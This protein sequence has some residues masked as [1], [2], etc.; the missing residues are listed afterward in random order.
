MIPEWYTLGLRLKT[1]SHDDINKKKEDVDTAIK[2]AQP[3][4][5]YKRGYIVIVFQAQ[6][7]FGQLDSSF[8]ALPGADNAHRWKRKIG[9]IDVSATASHIVSIFVAYQHD[10][11]EM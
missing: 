6:L 11:V 3:G 10:D 7:P 9:Q 2:K 5:E 1:W 4:D 8:S